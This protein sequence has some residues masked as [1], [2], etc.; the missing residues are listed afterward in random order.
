MECVSSRGPAA[1]PR[2]ELDG[3]VANVAV[4]APRRWNEV[5]LPARTEASGARYVRLDLRL[6][7]SDETA[8]WITKVQPLISR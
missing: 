7:S 3:R 2:V 6:L 4:L 5:T 1:A 8:I